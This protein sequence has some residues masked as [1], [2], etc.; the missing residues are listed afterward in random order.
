MAV[1]KIKVPKTPKSAFNKDRPASELLKAQLEHLEAASG[2][3]QS[4]SSAGRRAK[5]LTEGQAANRI[6]ELTRGLHPMAEPP[7]PATVANPIEESPARAR[8]SAGSRRK[9]AKKSTPRKGGHKAL[10]RKG[11]QKARKRG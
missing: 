11:G 6:Y 2:N 8:R 3:Y 5:P 1:M 10:K 4:A 7:A 9:A